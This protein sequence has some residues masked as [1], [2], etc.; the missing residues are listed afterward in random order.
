MIHLKMVDSTLQY[1]EVREIGYTRYAQLLGTGEGMPENVVTNQDII[2]RFNLIASDRAVQYSVGI[3]ERRALEKGVMPSEYLCKAVM[4][5][6]SNASIA[7]EK[8][9]RIIYAKLAG[10]QLIPATSLKVLQK[11]GIRKGIPVMDISVACSGFLH[12]TE[13]ALSCID[14]GDDYVL[15][16]GGDR[17]LLDP[18]AT[19]L[20]DTR[21]IFLNGDGFAAALFGHSETKKFVCK[22]FYTDSSIGE[23]AYIPFGTGLLKDKGKSLN[24][25][26]NLTMPDGPKIHQSILDSF[27][28]ISSQLLH[29]SGMQWNDIDFIIT[30]DQTAMAWKAQLE[31]IGIPESKSCSCFHKYGNTVAA[32]V[33]LNLHEAICSRKLQRGMTVMM[34][35][36]GAGASGGGFI[37][38]Y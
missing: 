33:P 8:I 14:T 4:Q 30:S 16:L 7:P 5:C 31:L 15:V 13:I 20:K 37:F 18:D 22:Y 11:L 2:D 27:R 32:M 21:T 9:D 23:F 38:K 24:G 26:F 25:A 12:A 28:I 6:C 19:I 34:M 35:G 10:D 3:K 1:P 36:H 29:A 17:A